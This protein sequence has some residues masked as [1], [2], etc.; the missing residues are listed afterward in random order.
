MLSGYL[1]ATSASAVNTDGFMLGFVGG[2]ANSA[3][4]GGLGSNIFWRG[5][6]PFSRTTYGHRT[7]E[8][9]IL[10]WMVRPTGT[11]GKIG[12]YIAINGIKITWEFPTE[13]L[14]TAGT[15]NSINTAT[16]FAINSNVGASAAAG[17]GLIA[18]YA[19][20]LIYNAAL[21]AADRMT[22]LRYLMNKYG[23][24]DNYYG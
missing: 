9:M 16:N 3:E 17:A 5:G 6:E 15:I 23:I 20:V 18:K 10:E 7:G 21:S 12:T 2:V 14:G 19:G 4:L 11:A 22:T 13:T 1:N 8:W 24:S